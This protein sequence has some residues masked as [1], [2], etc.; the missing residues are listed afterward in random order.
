MRM[1]VHFS[2]WKFIRHSDSHSC[3]AVRSSW[4]IRLSLW[5]FILL[6]TRLSL[7]YANNRKG[8]ITVPEGLL[9]WHPVGRIYVLQVIQ[10]TF[11]CWGSLQSNLSYL[12]WRSLVLGFEKSSSMTSVCSPC[13]MFFPISSSVVSSWVSYDLL[14]LNPCCW[15]QSTWCWAKWSMMVHVL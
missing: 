13:S 4:S 1:V 15:S 10:T 9:K 2:G 3:G 6:Y 5:F 8:P 14:A 12:L 11:C 7:I